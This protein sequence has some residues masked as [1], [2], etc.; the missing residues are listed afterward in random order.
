MRARAARK[1]NTGDSLRCEQLEARRVVWRWA[2][3]TLCCVELR[4]E[5]IVP[6][7]TSVVR[8]G[9]R[10]RAETQL[11]APV[12]MCGEQYSLCVPLVRTRSASLVPTRRATLV[13]ATVRGKPLRESRAGDRLQEPETE[14]RGKYSGG[15][16]GFFLF[17]Q[18]TNH[19]LC[20]MYKASLQ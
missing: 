6:A 19:S 20:T 12:W 1:V 5:I 9:L 10:E 7:S 17:V 15:H 8:G 3:G 18:H 16:R 14:C 4:L 13:P 2:G 11:R